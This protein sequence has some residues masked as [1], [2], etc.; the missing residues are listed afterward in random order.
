MYLQSLEMVGFKSFAPK[1]T[2]HFNEG[3]TAVVG[4]NGCGKSNVLDALR[5]V[6]G[7]Q[8]A[9]ALRGG[10]MSDVIFSGT[11]SRQPLGMAEV[12]LTFTNCEAELGVEWN[13]VRITRRVFR[14]GKSDYLLNK[15]PCRL[16]DI[17]ELFMDTGI[18]RSAYSV[19]EQGKIDAILSSRPED[20]RAIF[21]E[22]AGITKY[23]A[24][25]KE[26]LRK[27][28]YTDANLL[29]VSDI[30]KEVKRQIGSLQR[31]AGKAR[32]YQAL[33]EDMRTFDTHL[34]HRNYVDLRSDLDGVRAQLAGA[35]AA[36]SGHEAEI[37]SREAE[38]GAL[39]GQLGEL[40]AQVN[41]TRDGIQTQRNRIY[42]AETRIASNTERCEEA[43]T[44][45]ERNRLEIAACEEKRREQENQIVRTDAMISEMLDLLRSGEQ[46]L[47]E[48]NERLRV[49]REDRVNEE[50][51]A[52]ELNSGIGRI[53]AR[54]SDLRRDVSAAAGKREA[55]EARLQILKNEEAG[56]HEA[57]AA[58]EG[59]ATEAQGRME[60]TAIELESA[61]AAADEAQSSHDDAQRARQQ[62]EVEWNAANRTLTEQ[63]SRLELL[64]QLAEAGEGFGEGTQAVLRGLDNAELFKPALHGA[65]A[66]FIEVE[67]KFI[68]AVEAA[69]GGNLQALV[70]KDPSVAAA[71]IQALGAGKLGRA[72]IVPRDWLA[73]GPQQDSQELP[74]GALAW[75]GDCIAIT[76][77]VGELARRLLARV[78]V[79]DGIDAAFDLKTR[80]R[81]LGFVTLDGDFVSREGIVHG[82]RTG[83]ASSSALARKNQIRSL[84]KELAASQAIVAEFGA[85]RVAAVETFDAAQDALRAMRE[86]MQSAQVAHSTARNE[87]TMLERQRAEAVRRLEN[88]SREAASLEQSVG[89]AAARAAELDSGMGGLEAALMETRQR[90]GE[91]AARIEAARDR[92]RLATD[93]LNELRVRVATERQQQETLARQRGPLTAR[94]AELSDLLDQRERDI[95]EYETRI[96]SLE[97]EAAE[98]QLSIENWKLLLETGEQEIAGLV[99]QRGGIQERAD[100]IESELRASRRQ[101]AEIQEARGRC[102]VRGTQLEMRIE[103][104]CE[105]VMQRYQLALDE[106]QPDNDSLVVALRDREKRKATEGP[107]SPEEAGL[108]E[109]SPAGEDEG[110][111]W[112]RI[113]E[114]VAELSGKLDGMGPVNLD[115]IQEY[116]EL[117]ERH[118]FLEQQNTDLVNSKAELLEVISKINRTTRELFAETFEKIRGNFQEMF[119]ELFGGGKANLILTDESDPLESGIE[120]IAKPPGKQL[121][122][123]TLLS[124]GEKTMTAVA[125]LFSIYMVKPSPFCVL[126]EMDAP[127]DESNI[128][129]FIKIL[130]RFVGQSQFVVITHNKR[131]I[132]RADTVFGVTMEEHG[133]SKIVGVKFGGSDH[134]H[135]RPRSVA[136]SFGK[137]G[138]L[139]SRQEIPPPEA[140][141]EIALTS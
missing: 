92:E 121:Q 13:E 33:M 37:E 74:E 89:E 30:I 36:R 20:R 100:A 43:R 80:H 110:V 5:W 141:A 55:G 105:H 76:D 104:V 90:Q 7:E 91:A 114:L 120:I 103:H 52:Q 124:G 79:V 73:S 117:E 113:E 122:S 63:E 69:L 25:K 62:I 53:E 83:G 56:A 101:L 21:E 95:A 78:A 66:S 15:S 97:A 57:L 27:L 126:D 38:L 23:K 11:D 116:D 18:G 50:R 29:R 54:L 1:T 86:T 3:V 2:L 99:A 127:L 22:A 64:R 125:L 138:N 115:A 93:E 48:A 132:A 68:P 9:K 19:M 111:P 28:E 40:E 109:S 82:G 77:P 16:K 51:A 102:E 24:Q 14:D 107:E 46:Q 70:F 67:A 72:A 112:G 10:E 49:V 81:T 6:L 61:Q 42:S 136:E 71:A 59:R 4:P 58:A 130:D 8:S 134:E 118:A 87:M 129:R 34:S 108:V 123:I 60:S 128:S 12:S 106:F 44:M 17:H 39:R 133:V 131:T 88:F 47:S 135:A 65:L 98:F 119:T 32:R 140:S 94:V 41:A 75:A 45:I 31:Q 137:H 139:H 35:E 26:A 84:E 85:K 96:S